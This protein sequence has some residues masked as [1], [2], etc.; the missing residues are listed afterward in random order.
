MEHFAGNN[1]HGT[2]T[3][4]H[5]NR[6]LWWLPWQLL[7]V[8]GEILTSNEECHLSH[9]STTCSG[10]NVYLCYDYVHLDNLSDISAYQIVVKPQCTAM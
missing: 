9:S 8:F 4:M 6:L 2:H 1:D 10:T 5:F 7:F 3:C